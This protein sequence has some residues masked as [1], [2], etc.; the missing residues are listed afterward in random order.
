M[1]WIKARKILAAALLALVAASAVGCYA[2]HRRYAYYDY[3]RSDYRRYD[4]RRDHDRRYDRYD[5]HR[6]HDRR[7]YDRD[8]R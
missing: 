3:D 8:R 2:P 4:H 6:D 5:W 1:E 7:H